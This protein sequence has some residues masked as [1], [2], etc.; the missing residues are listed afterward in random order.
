MPWPAMSSLNKEAAAVPGLLAA[1]QPAVVHMNGSS[2]AVGEKVRYWSTKHHRWVD[3]H[4]Q[5]VNRGPAGTV[6]S[7]DLTAKAQAEVSKVRDASSTPFDAPPPAALPSPLV[8]GASTASLIAAAAALSRQ[9]TGGVPSAPSET[10]RQRAVE[11]TES[12]LCATEYEVGER[13]EYWSLSAGGWVPAKVLKLYADCAQCDL[14][15]KPG[16][17]LGRLRKASSGVSAG[18]VMVNVVDAVQARPSPPGPKGS[19][20]SRIAPP[21]PLSCAFKGGDQVQY[22]SE[23]KGR[24][25]EAVVQCMREKDGA[26]VYDLDCKKG[27]PADR[28]RPSLVAS[29][30]HYQVGEQVEYWS[31]SAGRWLPARVLRLYAHLGQCDLDIKPGAPL[32]RLRRANDKARVPAVLPRREEADVEAE[33]ADADEVEEDEQEAPEE[34][35][36]EEEQRVL[37]PTSSAGGAGRV[38]DNADRGTMDVV[39]PPGRGCSNPR[40]PLELHRLL[41]EAHPKAAARPPCVGQWCSGAKTMRIFEGGGRLAVDMGPLTP[42]LVLVAMTGDDEKAWPKQWSA[43]RKSNSG[44]SPDA[45]RALYIL[46]LANAASEMLLVKRPVGEGQVEFVRVCPEE[47]LTKPNPQS[48]SDGPPSEQSPLCRGRSRSSRRP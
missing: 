20:S 6:T 17:P 18:K 27:S 4:V 47:E 28:V 33:E 44:R 25:L 12:H 7:Y 45:S 24:W 37:S 35:E 29:Q 43:V 41:D 10:R 30:Y 2:F 23:T 15:L 8:L 34:G 26:V 21:P 36:E 14:D 19:P 31:T 13:V 5:R 32:G 16:A 42:T 40:D 11:T 1:A 38:D 9:S 39:L 3:A 22:W 46:E 48:G